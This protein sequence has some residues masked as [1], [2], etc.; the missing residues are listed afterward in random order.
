MKCIMWMLVALIL[1]M[2]T[3][4][5]FLYFSH[6]LPHDF[7]VNLVVSRLVRR[8]ADTHWAGGLAKVIHKLVTRHDLQ[9]YRLIE[10]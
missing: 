7:K 1:S 8:I 3:L 4:V 10:N 5:L 2:Q 9:L 6:H